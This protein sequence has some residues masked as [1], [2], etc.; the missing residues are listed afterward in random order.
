[1]KSIL[2]KIKTEKENKNKNFV[3][4]KDLEKELVEIKCSNN[5]GKL[6]NA[7]KELNKIQVVDKK[8]HENK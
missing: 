7:S 1:M 5:P 8:L 4:I 6:Q 2:K 3:K